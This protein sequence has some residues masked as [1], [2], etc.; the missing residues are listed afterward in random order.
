MKSILTARLQAMAL[1]VT[2][3][4]ATSA[5]ADLLNMVGQ[6]GLYATGTQE[7]ILNGT[8][9]VPATFTGFYETGGGP[10]PS[11]IGSH[12]AINQ[13]YFVGTGPSE[14]WVHVNFFVFD[15]SNVSVPITSAVLSF[16]ISTFTGSSPGIYST[17]D[18]TTPISSLEADYNGQTNTAVSSAIFND[19]GS[20][21]F[22]GSTV[23][24]TFSQ[25]SQVNVTLDGA[26]ISSLNRAV[27][28]NFAIGGTLST[29]APAYITNSGDGTVSVIDTTSNT[30]V[31]TILVGRKPF[32]VAVTPD[33]S[34]VYV[35]NSG[36]G[37]VSV[38]N[39]AT[40]EV[41]GS[42]AVGTDPVGVAVTPDSKTVY[43]TN[44]GDGTVSVIN[45][46]TNTAIGSAINVGCPIANCGRKT[47]NIPSG[48]AVTPD[49]SKVYVGNL[50]TPG[51]A[52]VI[53]TASNTVTTINTKKATSGL[54]VTPD[55]S[56]VYLGCSN[57]TVL[58]IDVA[59][60]S[61]GHGSTNCVGGGSE[62]VAVTPDG[63]KVYVANSTVRTVSVINTGTN[64][65]IGS[66]AVGSDPQGVSVTS[67]G[68]KVYV[69]NE[70]NG[71]V[72][73]TVSI[74]DT[75]TNTVETP[76]ITVGKAPLGIFI[77]P[78]KP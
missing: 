44:Q 23:V 18:V 27:G 28:G 42:I 52:S 75:A 53:A 24:G 8:I 66:I 67:D 57:G 5:Q 69:A 71:T 13:N 46:A 50:G 29:A 78:P 16:G 43:V 31:N 12:D 25:Y 11:Y 37:T 47:T 63:S 62:G 30:F 19:L 1:V 22:Y 4:A 65:V 14:D 10:P 56:K 40:N 61:V 64:K 39:P 34:K 77:P 76:T 26:A 59:T 49:G 32:G 20:G 74:I 58:A 17:W 41:I 7:L 73:G 2:M 21:V 68:S 3:L 45:T 51:Y 72:D 6:S 35:V 70:G 54:A 15:L 60:N 55:G 36:D 48:I 33:G 9:V 38:I